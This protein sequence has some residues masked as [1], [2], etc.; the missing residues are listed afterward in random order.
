MGVQMTIADEPVVKRLSATEQQ[1]LTVYEAAVEAGFGSQNAQILALVQIRDERL[2]RA[3]YGT[4]DTYCERRWGK[5]ASRMNQ[6]IQAAKVVK[7]LTEGPGQ[8][9]GQDGQS[10]AQDDQLVGQLP[11]TKQ[12]VELARLDDPE[13]QR[14]VWAEVVSSGEPV[15]AKR[16]EEAVTQH[17]AEK[18]SDDY[19]FL[20][21]PDW[22][23]LQI[24]AAKRFLNL[25]GEQER[26]ALVRFIGRDG[27]PSDG[28]VKALETFDRLHELARK[29]LIEMMGSKD[30]RDHSAVVAVLLER[31]P[32]PDIRCAE[33]DAFLPRLKRLAGLYDDDAAV[34]LRRMADDAKR[35]IEITNQ[36]EEQRI[37][38]AI[39]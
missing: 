38:A 35:V 9:V 5:S 11:N 7:N 12:A 15:T 18:A 20:Q 6:L 29:R 16:V 22:S 1:R 13:D 32:M 23:K 14:E 39:A 31:P 19:A 8:Q 34:V 10:Q 33:M 28:A 30:E 4:F 24:L 27:V 37:A 21:R 25:L 26:K 17:Q 36:M 2:Y 3:E